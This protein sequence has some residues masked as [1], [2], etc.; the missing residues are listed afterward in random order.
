MVVALQH[1]EMFTIEFISRHSL[2]GIDPSDAN[3]TRMLHHYE[4]EAE[5]EAELAYLAMEDDGYEYR[6]KESDS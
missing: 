6:V 4:T 1:F 3:W 2:V 5:A